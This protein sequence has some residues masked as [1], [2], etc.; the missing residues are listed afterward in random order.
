MK[1]SPTTL[2][3]LLTA[4]GAATA[5]LLAPTALAT[6]TVSTPSC[7]VTGSGGGIQG[8]ANTVCTSPGST[9]VDSRPSVYAYP[10]PGGFG[11]GFGFGF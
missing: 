8:G 4:G 5:L 7:Y 6:P 11:F 3:S 2:S 9:Q 1:L 10:W